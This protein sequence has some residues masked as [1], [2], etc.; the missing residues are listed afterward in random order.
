[1]KKVFLFS[2]ICAL[3]S[4][5]SCEVIE[6]DAITAS[7]GTVTRYIN[8]DAGTLSKTSLDDP[9]K[10]VSYVTWSEGDELA[11][12]VKGSGTIRK[13]VLSSGAGTGRGTFSITDASSSEQYSYAVYPY[14]Y[15]TGVEGSVV[16]V[17]V[18]SMQPFPV[19]GGELSGSVFAS[20]VNP[21]VGTFSGDDV[22][23]SSLCGVLKVP[24]RASGGSLYGI[25]LQSDSKKLSGTAVIDMSDSQ[26]TLSFTDNE[27]AQHYIYM[28][29]TEDDVTIPLSTTATPIY[30]VLPEGDYDDLKISTFALKDA[31][32]SRLL[33]S[34]QPHTITRS[35]VTPLKSFSVIAQNANAD[36]AINLCVN[37][38]N[39]EEEFANC[40][41]V[42]PSYEDQRYRVKMAFMSGERKILSP[43]GSQLFNGS[44]AVAY[45]WPLWESQDGLLK[46][47]ERYGDWVYFTVPG[48][49]T[50]NALLQAVSNKLEA[51]WAC[52]I[53]VSD[54][55]EQSL[56]NGYTFLDRNLGATYSPHSTSE[57]ASMSDDQI[58][59]TFGCYYQWGNPVPKPGIISPAEEFKNNG[60]VL[61][62]HLQGE[63][64]QSWKTS[65]LA[66]VG[67]NR[68]YTYANYFYSAGTTG[69]WTTANLETTGENAWWQADKTMLDP[70][71]PGYHV[72]DAA[73]ITGNLQGGQSYD[74]RLTKGGNYKEL[75]GEFVWIPF[76][77]ARVCGNS[78]NSG[79]TGDLINY[80]DTDK[81]GSAKYYPRAHLWFCGLDEIATTK[82]QYG[83]KG[84]G[85]TLTSTDYN[86]VTHYQYMMSGGN[87]NADG[88][89]G[90]DGNLY[91]AGPTSALFVAVAAS[92][93]CVK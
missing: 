43:S 20:G 72:P 67:F 68:I 19:E 79:Y 89:G 55:Q 9:G 49:M 92:V 27:K 53:W 62:K 31:R 58:I 73:A 5:V 11:V 17:K 65:T 29:A 86:D 83:W 39:G 15:V 41:I 63:Y 12:V 87:V 24:V 7:E 57:V 61:H 45:V 51:Q 50:G 91:A 2:A 26:P 80:F 38:D 71:P 16:N 76:A 1:M 82:I 14:D 48:G 84:V 28:N 21:M 78:S 4:A 81:V 47:V 36:E 59:E 60:Y 30:F 88:T 42:K 33:V 22:K 32:T 13:A 10:G 44:T 3:L 64:G 46:D 90:S 69:S 66:T 93:R 34:T 25:Q 54:V 6:P 70:C 74:Y 85:S 56:T 37:P 23:L 35:T 8:A 40:Y 52:H 18:P 75:E 77:G